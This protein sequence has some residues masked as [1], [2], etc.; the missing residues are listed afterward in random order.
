MT[1][2]RWASATV[3]FDDWWQ[4]AWV[5]LHELEVMWYAIDAK[6]VHTGLPGEYLGFQTADWEAKPACMLR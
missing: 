3:A 1:T 4:H 6:A 2:C 5:V